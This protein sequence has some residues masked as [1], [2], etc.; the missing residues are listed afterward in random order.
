MAGQNILLHACQQMMIDRGKS[1]N[2]LV[3]IIQLKLAT[4]TP[5]IMMQFGGGEGRAPESLL[6]KQTVQDDM[7]LHLPS[8]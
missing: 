5:S 4:A 2:F 8:C 7:Q 1:Q 6:Q 3:G